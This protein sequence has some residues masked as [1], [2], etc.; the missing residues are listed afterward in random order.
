MCLG[1]RWGVDGRWVFRGKLN[2]IYLVG[3]A[4]GKYCSF[5]I[6]RDFLAQI[7]LPA[8]GAKL[9]LAT[10]T[11]HLL[12]GEIIVAHVARHYL[13]TSRTVYRR[14]ASKAGKGERK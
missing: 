8:P 5:G 14:E 2:S 13:F 1:C 12:A 7:F 9:V 10:H 3:L 6:Q 11:T 4:R